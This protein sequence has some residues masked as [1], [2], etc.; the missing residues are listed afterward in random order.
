MPTMI[1]IV[2]YGTNIHG[3]NQYKIV[4]GHGKDVHYVLSNSHLDW[5]LSNEYS[6]FDE[7]GCICIYKDVFYDI[8]DEK[9]VDAVTRYRNII[10]EVTNYAEMRSKCKYAYIDYSDI[11]NYMSLSF[12]AKLVFLFEV[13]AILDSG[14]EVRYDTCP[15]YGEY[16]EL[17]LPPARS[18]AVPVADVDVDKFFKV[19]G[20]LIVDPEKDS[21][22]FFRWVPK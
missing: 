20:R 4:N 12:A 2:Q 1:K 5:I 3:H 22:I 9:F 13:N 8:D 17:F 6:T 18:V 11:F 21:P 14:E 10:G 15:P 19:K 7:F 16:L